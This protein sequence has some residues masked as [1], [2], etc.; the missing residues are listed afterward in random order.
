MNEV[1]QI[2]NIDR[3]SID[4]CLAIVNGRL[5]VMTEQIRDDAHQSVAFYHQFVALNNDW[6]YYQSILP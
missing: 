3:V 5:K 1:N 2:E 6:R 4:L